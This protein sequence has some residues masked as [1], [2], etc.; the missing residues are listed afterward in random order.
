M[1]TFKCIFI[2]CLPAFIAFTMPQKANAQ[3]QFGY[4]SYSKTLKNMPEYTN[5]QNALQILKKKYDD[6]AQYNEEKFKK[7]F[8]DY[9]QGQKNFPEQIMLKR[10]KELQVAMEQGISFRQDAQQLLT[11]AENDLLRPIKQKLDSIL[12][13]IGKENGFSFIANTDGNTLPFIHGQAGKDIT[14]IV[15][16]RINGKVISINTPNTKQ[17]NQ[18][19]G[20][21]TENEITTRPET[22]TENTPSAP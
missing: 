1:K 3:Y 4:L 17:E 6:E 7:M 5:A 9:L 21:K 20:I 10:Q 14:S 13:L 16:A 19:P 22:S 12:A 15:I 11:K 18:K 2:F 8:A